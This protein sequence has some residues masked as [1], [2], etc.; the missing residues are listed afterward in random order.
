MRRLR[1]FDDI[2][3]HPASAFRFAEFT[4][5]LKWFPSCHIQSTGTAF[6]LI[7]ESRSI[8]EL[9]SIFEKQ[10]PEF[11]RR[12]S[13]YQKNP[14]SRGVTYVTFLNNAATIVEEVEQSGGSLI[15]TLYPG[16][17]FWLDIPESDV[18][19]KRVLQSPSFRRVIATQKVTRDYLLSKR[20]C[21]PEQIEFIYGGVIP[22][23]ILSA[24]ISSRPRYGID[25]ET[26]DI[27]FAAFK[28]IPGARDKG[29]DIFIESAKRLTHIGPHLRFH[30]AGPFSESDIDATDLPIQF[31][32]V[33]PTWQ[34]RRFYARLDAI[35]SPNASSMIV[36]GAFD[37]FPTGCSIEAALCG[38]AVFCTDPMNQNLHFRDGEDLVIIQRDAEEIAV[39]LE[40]YIHDYDRLVQLG[41]NGARTF[42]NVYGWDRQMRPRI[43]LLK[44]ECQRGWRALFA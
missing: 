37:G 3:P 15:M 4:E 2:F 23:E 30:V 36:P 10:R 11:S 32:G 19:L 39:R 18:K 42:K 38:V 34:M 14:D 20:W 17:G 31:H 44:A 40:A 5:Y 22:L 28:Y 16:G 33:M 13:Q 8:S 26:I 25:K 12:I 27:G 21:A 43:E 41:A 24:D 35:V 29:F 7:H 1:I 9:I 6:P